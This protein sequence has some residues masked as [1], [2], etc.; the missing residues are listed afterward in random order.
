VA[1]LD[2]YN[3]LAG[4]DWRTRRSVRTLATEF[5]RA[6]GLDLR[7]RSGRRT[8]REQDT[9]YAQGRGEDGKSIV[10]QA[11]GCQSWHVMGRAI[12]ADPVDP[13]TGK[14]L[15]P[16][17][18]DGGPYAVAGLIWE[19]LGGVWGGRFS[20]KDYGHFEWHPDT[21]RISTLCPDPGQ[22]EQMAIRIATA[23]P[24]ETVGPGLRYAVAGFA[25]AAALLWWMRK[26]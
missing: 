7:I 4:L 13:S 14:M 9:I 22:C 24:P 16:S 3:L 12:D 23:D 5:K 25:V 6:T 1:I 21:Q 11:R 20:F 8:C 26:T 18:T 17:G 19:K 10:T 15:F 2:P